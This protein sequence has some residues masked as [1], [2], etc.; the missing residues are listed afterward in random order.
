MLAL[1]LIAL[2]VFLR[3]GRGLPGSLFPVPLIAAVYLLFGAWA[4]F[5]SGFTVMERR[6]QV[7]NA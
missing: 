2:R 6:H 4:L 7:A 1:G 3:R 5:V